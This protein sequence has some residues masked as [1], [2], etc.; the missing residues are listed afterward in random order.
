MFKEALEKVEE[1]VLFVQSSQQSH[2]NDVS[3]IFIANF[4]H[5]STVAVFLLLTLN[6]HFFPKM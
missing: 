3:N 5:T 1:G 6:M 2:L 4:Q